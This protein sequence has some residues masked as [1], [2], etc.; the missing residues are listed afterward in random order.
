MRTVQIHGAM[1]DGHYLHPDRVSEIEDP[2]LTEGEL[3][4][5]L[6]FELGNYGATERK[7]D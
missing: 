5:A 1:D 2:V 4:K 6:S 7:F 3:A